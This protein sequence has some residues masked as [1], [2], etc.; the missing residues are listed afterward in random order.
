MD[1]SDQYRFYIAVGAKIR[2]AR[3][4][5]NLNQDPFG[6]M[7]NL[8]RTSIINIEKGRQ[9]PSLHLLWDIAQILE[10]EIVELFPKF[11]VSGTAI[12]VE[13]NNI[14]EKELHDKES[15]MKISGFVKEIRSRD[16]KYAKQKN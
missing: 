7:L 10:I 9:H 4:K 6:K 16:K 1:K 2:E 13:W 15:K 14:I 12:D 11:E 3:T 8:T 5:A